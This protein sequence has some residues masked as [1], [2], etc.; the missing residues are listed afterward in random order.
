[1]R[2]F[3]VVVMLVASSGCA[4]VQK[5]DTAI[6]CNGICDRY[7]SC[8]DSS[9]DTSA[10][11]SRCRKSASSD[12]DF[13]RKADQCMACISERSCVKATV[14]CVADCVSVVP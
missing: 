1:M 14:A 13:R 3:L 7:A 12:A 4:V 6:D 9:Y 8:F 10:C 11:A 2:T 5:I